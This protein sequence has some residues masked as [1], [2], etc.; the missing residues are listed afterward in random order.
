[1]GRL[2]S[3]KIFLSLLLVSCPPAGEGEI[4]VE[5][6]DVAPLEVQREG[7]QTVIGWQ[8]TGADRV[9]YSV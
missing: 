5:I 9:Y 1:M 7:G 2:R 8:A 4:S 6:L 3:T